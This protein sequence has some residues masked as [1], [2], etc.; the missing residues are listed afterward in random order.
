[1]ELFVHIKTSSNNKIKSSSS[2]NIGGPMKMFFGQSPTSVSEAIQCAVS[3]AK[4]ELPGATLEWLE[5]G[6]IR[7]GFDSGVLQFQVSVRIGYIPA[8]A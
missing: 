6:E 1:M 5:L 7:G 3:A 8:A 2:N 4:T